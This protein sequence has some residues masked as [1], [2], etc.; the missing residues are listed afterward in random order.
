VL[1]ARHGLS[2]AQISLLFVVWSV[3]GFVLEVPTGA[4]ADRFS[5]RHLLA[6]AQV[7]RAA[8]YLVWWLAPSFEGFAVGFVLWGVEGA[9]TSGAFQA[10]VYDELRSTGE[11]DG[12]ARV[13]GRGEACSSGGAVVGS[14]VA[15]A[16][17]PLGFGVL[18]VASSVVCLAAAAIVLSFPP[19]PAGQP[20]PDGPY[21]AVLRDG[22]REAISRRPLLGFVLFSGAVV[23]FGAVEEFYALVLH[24]TGLSRAGISLWHAAFFVVA[25]AGSLLAHRV[26]RVSW[27]RLAAIAVVM[28][29]TLVTAARVPSAAVPFALL[30]FQ[31]VYA[32]E[33]VALDAR[34]QAMV[35]SR[36]R[37]TVTSVQGFVTEVAA[38]TTF[39]GFGVVASATSHRTATGVVGGALVAVGA[40]F[41]ATTTSVRVRRRRL[42]APLSK[43]VESRDHEG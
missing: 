37:A 26:S 24:D 9:T 6:L 22:I 43:R 34:L 35:T 19:A 1:F 39:L 7:I 28:G 12:Y 21:L 14:L 40:A 18:L 30:T 27:H 15:A 10:L 8:G 20:G 36:A 25:V 3:V 33:Y 38:I 13:M 42:A 29:V 17:I 16:A 41:A 11:A 32:L 4:L 23:G 5:R 2:A 31:G